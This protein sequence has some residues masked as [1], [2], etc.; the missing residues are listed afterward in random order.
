MQSSVLIKELQLDLYTRFYYALV[1]SDNLLKALSDEDIKTML[2]V[3]SRDATLIRDYSNYKATPNTDNDRFTSA[4]K[5]P[6][7]EKEIVEEYAKRALKKYP[8]EEIDPDT[9]TSIPITGAE[10]AFAS[11]RAHFSI[12]GAK[13]LVL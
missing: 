10:I 13:S 2:Q 7:S 5:I 3:V 4:R 11:W 1:D 12:S 8:K 6:E 9:K